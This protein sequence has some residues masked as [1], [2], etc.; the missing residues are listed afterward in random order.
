MPQEKV[1]N[2]RETNMS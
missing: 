2:V 1:L